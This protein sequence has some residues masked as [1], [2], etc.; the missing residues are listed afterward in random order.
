MK[1]KHLDNKCFVNINGVDYFSLFDLF[2]VFTNPPIYY[3]EIKKLHPKD[4]ELYMFE[5]VS[6]TIDGKSV[7]TYFVSPIGVKRLLEI[8]PE[9]KIKDEQFLEEFIDSSSDLKEFELIFLLVLIFL[10][11]LF[12]FIS[13]SV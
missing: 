8:F 2:K 7:Y 12:G 4:Y 5:L 1:R 9:L 3:E 13:V 10:I 6:D 11:F